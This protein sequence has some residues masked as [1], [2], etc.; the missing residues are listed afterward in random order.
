MV[1]GFFVFCF[2]LLFLRT[3]ESRGWHTFSVMGQRLNI[4][5]SAVQ[6]HLCH[7]ASTLPL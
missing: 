7:G 3:T 1:F 4:L 2:V 5:C 6:T